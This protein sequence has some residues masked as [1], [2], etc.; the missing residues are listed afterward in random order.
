MALDDRA[1]ETQERLKGLLDKIDHFLN[2]V[3]ELVIDGD[4]AMHET[5]REAQNGDE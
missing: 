4:P 1:K 3:R 2:E 5:L